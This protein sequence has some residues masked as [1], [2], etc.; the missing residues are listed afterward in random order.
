MAWAGKQTDS[1]SGEGSA[2]GLAEAGADDGLAV[3]D[4]D[5]VIVGIMDTDAEGERDSDGE[6]EGD[7]VG[8]MD[9]SGDM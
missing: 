5:A 8:M 1:S 6:R 4:G 9:I 7:S 3:K 2:S